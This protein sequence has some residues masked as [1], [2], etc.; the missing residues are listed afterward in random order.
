MSF[1]FNEKNRR[2]VPDSVFWL[3]AFASISRMG[4]LFGMT[5]HGQIDI[6]SGA[7]AGLAR[8]VDE[9]AVVC[10]DAETTESPSPLPWP[11]DLVVKK[12]SK[13]RSRTLSSIPIPV[14]LTSTQT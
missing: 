11:G 2:R 7:A 12:G 3:V 10:N 4:Q 1:V 9:S 13:I 14:S 5:W 8:C 6:E